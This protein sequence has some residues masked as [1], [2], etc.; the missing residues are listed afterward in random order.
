MRARIH[1]TQRAQTGYRELVS[2]ALF[3]FVFLTSTFIFDEHAAQLF[4]PSLVSPLESL[5]LGSSV[6]GFILRPYLCYRLP[7]RRHDV[8]TLIGT[9]AVAAIVVTIMARRTWAFLAGGIALFATLGISA[10]PPIRSLRAA[11]PRRPI[12]RAPSLSPML[13]ESFFSLS[14]ASSFQA[15]CPTRLSSYSPRSPW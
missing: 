15:I 7:T 10:A 11:M 6:I 9:L 8:S 13:R 1:K 5:M 2:L 12:W 14:S 3:F 4:G